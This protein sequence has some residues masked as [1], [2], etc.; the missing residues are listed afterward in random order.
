MS[1]ILSSTEKVAAVLM[2]P[3]ASSM[4]LKLTNHWS[5][6]AGLEPMLSSVLL[7]PTSGGLHYFGYVYKTGHNNNISFT[8]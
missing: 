3:G 2:L 5:C 1:H 6:N 4:E 8:D 7:I